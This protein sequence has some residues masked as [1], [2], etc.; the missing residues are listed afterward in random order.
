MTAFLQQT[1]SPALPVILWLFRG[2]TA[3]LAVWLLFGWAVNVNEFSLNAFYR[4]RLVRCYLGASNAWRNPEPTTN[5]DVADDLP[6]HRLVEGAPMADGA[7]PLFPLIC[8][9]LNLVAAKQ[10][11]WQDRKAASFCLTPGWCGYLPPGSRRGA[12]SGCCSATTRRSPAPQRRRRPNSCGGVGF[13]RGSC[14]TRARS[15]R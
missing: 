12:T 9:A 7:R 14:S 10:L 4:N 8:T 15:P 5:F 2:V 3:G 11:D 6:L 1:I 13:G